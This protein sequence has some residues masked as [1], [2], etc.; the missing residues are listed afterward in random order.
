MSP[1]RTPAPL[2]AAAVIVRDGRVLLVRRRVAESTLSWQLPAGKVEPGEAAQE[3][4][5]REAKGGDRRDV[6]GLPCAR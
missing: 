4:A 5:V 3:A 6:R 2:I 1:E